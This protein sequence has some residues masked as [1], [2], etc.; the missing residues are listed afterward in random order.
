[1]ME[2]K[3]VH[4]CEFRLLR[5]VKCSIHC[6][7][8]F[9]TTIIACLIFMLPSCESKTTLDSDSL[10]TVVGDLAKSSR[11]SKTDSEDFPIVF[12]GNDIQWFN[13]QTREVKFKKNVDHNNFHTYQNIHFNLDGNFLFTA[14]TYASQYHSFVIN[15]LVLFIDVFT[16]KCYLYDCYPVE[17]MENDSDTQKNKEKRAA[18][19]TLFLKQLKAE[20][21]IKS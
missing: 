6:R 10:I 4:V 9:F 11:E 21:K 1:M 5:K 20:Q 8:M 2:N 17:I 18:A 14:R 16:Q 3:Y 13:P 15:D 12:T 7:K 19:W